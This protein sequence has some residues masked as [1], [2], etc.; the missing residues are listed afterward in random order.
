MVPTQPLR[1]VT[2]VIEERREGR[3][4]KSG[5]SPGPV[6]QN[7]RFSPHTGVLLGPLQWLSTNN[8]A[9]QTQQSEENAFGNH[10]PAFHGIAEDRASTAKLALAHLHHLILSSVCKQHP[11]RLPLP[12]FVYIHQHTSILSS[13]STQNHYESCAATG[14]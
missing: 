7:W 12:D 8:F 13:V 3:M 11:T 1:R 9:T 4:T 5:R 14:S 2:R 6:L 10:A